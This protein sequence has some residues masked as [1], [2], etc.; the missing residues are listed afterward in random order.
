M[1]E[2]RTPYQTERI[3]AA[4]IYCSDGR[5]GDHF[6]DFLQNGLK[7]PRYDRVALPGGP[8]ALVE[9]PQTKLEHAA[10]I[11]ELHF[12]VE[13][14]EI[15]RVV[16]IQHQNCA[17]YT[18]RLELR[19]FHVEKTQYDDLKKAADFVREVTSVGQ[20]DCY[21]ARQFDGRIRFEVVQF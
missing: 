6:D 15:E 18:R 10:V 14:H 4:A 11:D 16:L 19:G 7:L 21:F 5:V 8:A 20:V 17:F 2:S 13:V 1:F 3:R 12:L 9:Y